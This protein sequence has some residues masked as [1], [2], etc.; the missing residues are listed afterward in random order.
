MGK[1]ETARYF[2]KW[3]A[4]PFLP[5]LSSDTIINSA[6]RTRPPL[7]RNGYGTSTGLSKVQVPVSACRGP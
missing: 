1:Y 4:L 3:S 2:F 7:M 5:V 6:F